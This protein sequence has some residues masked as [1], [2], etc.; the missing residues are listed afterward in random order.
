MEYQ[1]QQKQAEKSI[2]DYILTSRGINKPISTIVDEEGHLR[3]K[4]KNETD[5]NTIITTIATN[6]P[7]KKTIIEKW[8]LNNNEGWENFNKEMNTREDELRNKEYP[9]LAKE[10]IEIMKKTV[11]KTK[12]RTDKEP[13]PNN[14]R[15]KEAKVIRKEKKATYQKTLKKTS[16][17]RKKLSRNTSQPKRT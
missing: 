16:L 5:H 6:L 12:I 11:G 4:R 15:I 7:R 17:R 10:V 14:A 13:K 1:S 2:I 8:N 9:D 3:V